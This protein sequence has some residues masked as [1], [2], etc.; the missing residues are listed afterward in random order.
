MSNQ[1]PQQYILQYED[2]MRLAYQFEGTKLRGKFKMATHEGQGASPADYVGPMLANDN[3]GRLATTPNNN[4]TVTR[5][6][7]YPNYFDVGTQIA[8]QDVKRVFNGGQ[9]QSGYSLA[10]GKA[11]ARKMDDIM[12]ES[13]FLASNTGQNGGTTTSFPSGNIIADNFG[14]A[15][16]TG[17]TVAKLI[18]AQ[19][20]LEAGAVDLE[21]E[22]VYCAITSADHAFLKKQIELRS[23]EYSSA[24]VLDNGRVTKFLNIEFI[25]LEFQNSTYY[26]R[27]AAV[28]TNNVGSG[29]RLI[30]IW[31]ESAMYL[32]EWQ[33]IQLRATERPDLSYAWQLYSFAECGAT[34]LQEAGVVQAICA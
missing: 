16:A 2:E 9:L 15:A 27:A 18:E 12:L 5:R 4:A 34:R 13:F 8:K 3:P 11:M 29:E 10:Q 28:M 22:K 26:P 30:P 33:P 20:I 21:T 7:V 14:A 1:I 23:D 24:A 6:W 17:L 32:A 31:A 25:H 19:R